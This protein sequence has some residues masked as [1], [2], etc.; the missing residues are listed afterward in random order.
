[1]SHGIARKLLFS[2]GNF[3]I[4]GYRQLITTFLVFF[5]VDVVHLDPWLTS[6]AYMISYGFW[7]ALSDMVIGNL[8]DRTHTRWG[9][10]K[11]WIAVGA[12]L[13]LIISFLLWYPILLDGEPLAQPRSISMFLYALVVILGFETATTMVR[14]PWSSLYPEMFKGVRERT[15]VSIYSEIF[16]VVGPIIVMVVLP[17]M[18]DTLE[19]KIGSLN[20][21]FWAAITMSIL[22]AVAS[23][24]G[25]VLGG[26]ERK[27]ASTEKHLSFVES[28]KVTFQSKS[29]IAF[30]VV[31]LMAECMIIWLSTMFPFLIKYSL[32]LGMSSLSIVMGVELLGTFAFYPVWRKVALRIGAKK[33][34]AISVTIFTT[35]LM[36]ISVIG[37]LMQITG[38]A[39][40]MGSGLAGYMT[41]IR[42][43]SADVIDEDEV[44]TGLRREGSFY[45]VLGA[46]GKVSI[47]ISAGAAGLVLSTMI[48]YVPGEPEPA[49]MG[50]GI[51]I[52]MAMFGF[53]F[54]LVMM[55]ALRFYPL[56]KEKVD[57]I[58]VKLKELHAGRAI[59]L[60]DA[61]KNLAEKVAGSEMAAD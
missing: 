11:P 19:G 12:P 5:L 36:L 13:G 26:K 61:K 8:S 23:F 32:G 43:M 18:V 44:K 35:A 7:N 34:Y 14:V 47:A 48:G 15:E 39:F 54:W 56:N 2:T 31:E 21:W 42:V 52:G 25:G 51:R 20:A 40:L 3:G 29:F 57:E 38:V 60:E 30:M 41:V 55:S 10:R 49:F 53:I 46:M 6:L 22:F 50:T 24:T 17:I 33:T 9:R 28:F 37:S 27:D 45:G 58:E 16:G 59:K 4:S 1:M